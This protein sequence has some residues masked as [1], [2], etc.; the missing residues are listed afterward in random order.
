MT[1]AATANMP[2]HTPPS[3]RQRAGFAA[4][5]ALA[6][7]AFLIVGGSA[8]APDSPLGAIT[9]LG[10]A[11][12]AK[13]LA[14]AVVLAATVAGA[15]TVL[16]GRRLVDVGTFAACIGLALTSLQGGTSAVILIAAA[17]SEADGTPAGVA[18]RFAFESAA[19]LLAPLAAMIVSALVHRRLFARPRGGVRISD[20]SDPAT[21]AVGP[22]R[23][24][25]AASDLR[26]LAT[27]SSAARTPWAVGAL[28]TLVA[29]C[30]AM[31]G[32]HLFSAGLTNR[33]IQHGQACFVVLAAIFLGT[34]L[35]GRFVPVRSA[36]WAI[37]AVPVVAIVGYF[38]ASTAGAGGSPLPDLPA[39]PFLRILP[40]QFISVG[41][42]TAIG[43][44]WW[45]RGGDGP[46]RV[47]A[48]AL[49]GLVASGDS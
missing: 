31:V 19:W 27:T 49:G 45:L 9:L 41:T 1:T 14:V 6:A 5:L 28:H 38:W 35:A 39:S 33:S 42:A 3:L 2:V 4:S 26:F 37:L 25:L 24:Q 18:M 36:L 48:F 30:V 8:L 12:G 17:D 21:N 40:L 44:A 10:G 23:L 11:G 29:S 15:A 16:A 22:A 7:G 47:G 20:E 43:T 32:I 13:T 34:W 46:E